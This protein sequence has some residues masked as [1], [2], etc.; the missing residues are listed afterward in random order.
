MKTMA[1]LLGTRKIQSMSN[2]MLVATI[3]RLTREHTIF[4]LKYD[5]RDP[6]TAHLLRAAIA[7]AERR[8]LTINHPEYIDDRDPSEGG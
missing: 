8:H 1:S 3:R 5:G 4:K 6:P 7:E 2:P